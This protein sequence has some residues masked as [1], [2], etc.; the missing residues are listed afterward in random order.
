MLRHEDAINLLRIETS[1]VTSSFARASSTRVAN[2]TTDEIDKLKALRWYD[3]S[4]TTWSCLRWNPEAK[5]LQR[6]EEKPGIKA[7]ETLTSLDHMLPV[8]PQQ[9]TVARFHPTRPLPQELSGET[10]TF[11]MQFG[12]HNDDHAEKLGSCMDKLSGLAVT[13]RMGMRVKPDRLRRS[14]LAVQI[15]AAYLD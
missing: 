10:V 13:Q 1:C 8:A 5:K 2:L 14:T 15:A 7:S 11:F 4:T 6:D 3:D 9:H 12:T